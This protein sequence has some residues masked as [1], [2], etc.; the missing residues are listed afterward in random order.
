[1]RNLHGGVAHFAG[2]LAEDGAEE[3]LFRCQL[4]FTLRGDLTDEDIA[5]AN[6]GTDAD[7]A[8]FVEVSED[9]FRR[10]R[11]I[12]GDFLWPELGVAGVDFVFLNVD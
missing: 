3:A 5:V 6:V 9:I 1:M 2:L 10:V 11:D 8:A 12:A 7:D 4:G